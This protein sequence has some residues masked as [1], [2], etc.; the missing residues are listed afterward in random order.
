MKK[1]ILGVIQHFMNLIEIIIYVINIMIQI[2]P[3]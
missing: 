1:D 2:I 3:I